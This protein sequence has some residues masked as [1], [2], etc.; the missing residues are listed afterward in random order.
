MNKGLLLS[1]RDYVHGLDGFG[2]VYTNEPDISNMRMAHA[3][4][5]LNKHTTDN[6]SNTMYYLVIQCIT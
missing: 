3:A 6:L 1:D 5:A 4:Y 2:D